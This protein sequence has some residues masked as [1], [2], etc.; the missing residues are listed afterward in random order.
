M[1]VIDRTLEMMK[2]NRCD[3]EPQ[4]YNKTPLI[5]AE[6]M[7]KCRKCGLTYKINVSG[8]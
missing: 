6:N 7:Y 5:Y 3:H 1:G 4:V 2:K 8:H